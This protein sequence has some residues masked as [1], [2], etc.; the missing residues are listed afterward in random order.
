[1]G[2][3][4]VI[5]FVLVRFGVFMALRA[6]YFLRVIEQLSSIPNHSPFGLFPIVQ[7]FENIKNKTGKMRLT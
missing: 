6:S 3:G 5:D 7:S 1:M 2:R 4:I